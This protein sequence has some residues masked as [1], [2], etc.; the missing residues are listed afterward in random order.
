MKA[1]RKTTSGLETGVPM[2]YIYKN[3]R[4]TNLALKLHRYIVVHRP[5]IV[6][7]FLGCMLVQWMSRDYVMSGSARELLP[8]LLAAIPPYL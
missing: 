2:Y 6:I 3:L 1:V 7:F 5:G 8:R 4:R